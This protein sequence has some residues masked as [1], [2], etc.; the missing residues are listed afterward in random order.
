MKTVQT[1]V[2][3]TL[4]ALTALTMG[5][6]QADACSC[7]STDIASSYNNSTDV[8]RAQVLFGITIGQDQWYVARSLS[9]FKG[10][11]EKNAWVYIRTAS[12]SAACGVI[13]QTGT[14]YLLSGSDLQAG[15]SVPVLSIGS[16]GF[17]RPIASLTKADRKFLLSRYNC[18]GD[19]C[20]CNDGTQPVNCFADPCMFADCPSGECVANYCGGCNAEFYDQYGQAVCTPCGAG[21]DCP[22]TQTCED[23]MCVGQ[24]Y[25]DQDCGDGFWCGESE[26]PNAKTCKAYSEAGESCGGFTAPWDQKKCAKGL[27]C[28]Y[29]NQIPDAP[30]VC[31]QGCESNDD[32]LSTEW[33][34]PTQD[35]SS[36]CKP[37]VKE[38]GSCGGFTPSWAQ[39]KCA[40]DLICTDFPD[41]I[42]DAP[43]T[44]RKQCEDNQDCT[45]DQYCSGSGVCRDDGSCNKLKDCNT[46]GNIYIVPA[47]VGYAT[48]NEGQCGWNCGDPTC[49][50]VSNVFF[51][52]CDA[53][54]GVGLVNGECTTLSGCDD[55]GYSL[56]ESIEACK[57]ACKPAID[58]CNL[59]GNE[60][61]ACAAILGFGAIDGECTWISGCGAGNV[62]L[63]ETKAECAAGCGSGPNCKDLGDV[64]FGECEMALGVA[65]VN[66]QCNYVSGCDDYGHSFYKSLDECK[67]AC[68]TSRAPGG[69]N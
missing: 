32:C 53:I 44:C 7:I 45:E 49:Q 65:V 54:V 29:N 57:E 48:C 17:N 51:G 61:G 52:F 15:W 24:C 18:C 25:S 3:A 37:Y 6:K 36:Q 33:C 5:P 2:L 28:V 16:C 59:Q 69:R 35:G 14:Q 34:S 27:E 22:W 67:T 1:A 64:D 58:V 68:S 8:I 20:A 9:T 66:G 11:I 23:G 62:Q 13:L 31:T 21:N 46:E 4:V 43:G 39:S 42:A 10:C 55:G 60:F 50:D 19:T 40:P 47:C 26:D 30:G 56:F 41:F 38:G 63:F 12:S